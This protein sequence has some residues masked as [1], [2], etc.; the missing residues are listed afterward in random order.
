MF[1]RYIK[2]LSVPIDICIHTYCILYRNGQMELIVGSS[3]FLALEKCHAKIF[4]MALV[5]D[6]NLVM[7]KM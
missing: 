1:I 4:T 5:Q 6:M 7:E 3:L 2:T